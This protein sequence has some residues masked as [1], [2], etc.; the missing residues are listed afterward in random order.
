MISRGLVF[1]RV[2]NP[3]APA[4]QHKNVVSTQKCIVRRLKE[5]R[6][7]MPPYG[8]NALMDIY[9]RARDVLTHMTGYI[10]HL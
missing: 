2:F 4:S 7:A 5:C 6:H 1:S 3:I 8:V 9:S 10:G